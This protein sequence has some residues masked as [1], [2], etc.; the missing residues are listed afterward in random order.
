MLLVVRIYISE[1]PHTIFLVCRCDS[2]IF[3]HSIEHRVWFCHQRSRGFEFNHFALQDN[4]I[5]ERQLKIVFLLIIIFNI[6]ITVIIIIHL[7]EHNHPVAVHDG[8]QSVSNRQHG[9]VNKLC[10]DGRLVKMGNF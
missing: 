1:S 4:M 10:S 2:S 6:I 9:A 5:K 3:C 7:I 8:V